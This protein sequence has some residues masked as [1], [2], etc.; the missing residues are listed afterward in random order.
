MIDVTDAVKALKENGDSLLNFLYDS[1]N[2][3]HAEKFT[4]NSNFNS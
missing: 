3:I 2:S 1:I 4:K